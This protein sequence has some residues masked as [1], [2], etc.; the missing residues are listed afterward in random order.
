M[1]NRICPGAAQLTIKGTWGGSIPLAHIFHVKRIG[2][3]QD[4]AW[5]GPTLLL[6]TDRLRGAFS[7]FLGNLA[8][9]ATYSTIVGK[10]L[11]SAVAPVVE[12]AI[13]LAGTDTAAPTG[14]Y[15]GPVIRWKTAFGGRT[16]GRTYLPGIGEAQVDSLGTILAARVTAMEGMATAFRAFLAAATDGTHLGEPLQLVVVSSLPDPGDPTLAAWYTVTS[17]TCR[18]VVGI[19]RRRRLGT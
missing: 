13:S 11:S 4:T 16:N 9:G 12:Q 2:A 5:T 6:A 7:S 1:P 18:S 3:N 19:Q 14:A 10:D 8:T 17:N 15:E